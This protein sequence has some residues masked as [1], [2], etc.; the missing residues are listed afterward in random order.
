MTDVVARE[1]RVPLR[2]V[3]FLA[4]LASLFDCSPIEVLRLVEDRLAQ[5]WFR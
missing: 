4:W 1:L 5:G 3:P 2:R